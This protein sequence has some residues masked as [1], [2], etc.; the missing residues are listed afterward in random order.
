MELR[1]YQS[2][3]DDAKTANNKDYWIANYGHPADCPYEPN[4]LLDI[5]EIIYD[6]AHDDIKS[7]V[8]GIGTKQDFSRLYDIPYRTVQNWCNSINS[9]TNYTLRLIGY[10][11]VVDLG[12]NQSEGD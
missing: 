6:V 2:L 4:Q 12:K 8:Q 3:V 9:I 1:Y 7:I 10:T 11:L 5:L